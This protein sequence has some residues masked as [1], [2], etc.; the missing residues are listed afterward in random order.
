MALAE[1]RSKSVRY[2]LDFV[3]RPTRDTDRRVR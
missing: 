1:L 3:L 2:G